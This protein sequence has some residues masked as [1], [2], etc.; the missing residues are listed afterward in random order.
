[1]VDT[2]KWGKVD[3]NRQHQA[4]KDVALESNQE[5]SCD[6]S[7]LVCVCFFFLSRRFYSDF[8]VSDGINGPWG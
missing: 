8:L 6:F 3:G 2:Q 1:M 5:G 4:A 7:L